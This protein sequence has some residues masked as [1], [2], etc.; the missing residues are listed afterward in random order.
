MRLLLFSEISA[1]STKAP[2][3]FLPPGKR[4]SPWGVQSDRWWARFLLRIQWNGK[5]DLF[6]SLMNYLPTVAPLKLLFAYFFLRAMT[7]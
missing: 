2:I 7:F 5:I 1:I 6:S 4:A 3:S